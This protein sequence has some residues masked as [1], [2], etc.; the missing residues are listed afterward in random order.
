M[1]ARYLLFDS[2]VLDTLRRTLS[3]RGKPVALTPKAVEVLMLLA[4]RAG[5][6]ITKELLLETLWPGDFA[7]ETSLAQHVY[8]LRKALAAYGGDELIATVPRR[9]YRFAG[10]ARQAERLEVAAPTHVPESLPVRGERALLGVG[11]LVLAVVLA[12]V[13]GRMFAL[14][15]RPELAQLG[16]AAQR[17]YVL[18]RY[19][20]NKRDEINLVLGQREFEAVMQL[21]PRSALGYSGAADVH[22]QLAASDDAGNVK[23][24]L[25]VA[26]QL[27]AQ[28]VAVDPSSAEA[29]ASYG[30]ALAYRDRAGARREYLR[31]IALKPNY[32]SAHQWYANLSLRDGDFATSISEFRVAAALEPTSVPI[33]RWLGFAY[34]YAGRYD[35]A[36]EQ[37]HQALKLDPQ[38]GGARLH[39]A[40][41]LEQEDRYSE[42]IAQLKQ[43]PRDQFDAS[44]LAAWTAY[45]HALEGHADQA[46][47]E[48][49]PI[50]HSRLRDRVGSPSIAAVLDAAGHRSEA[51]AYLKRSHNLIEDASI[52]PR[53][54]PRI[55]DLLAALYPV[56][57]R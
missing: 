10:E 9:G 15:A 7:Q 48:I 6:V 31:A 43:L 42:A 13:A 50:L 19:Y 24:E 52:F 5:Q 30:F 53:Y 1:E 23:R 21:A 44:Q 55:G 57:P 32:P 49:E 46:L 54:D 56:H 16:P 33:A 51:I 20:W 29:H 25:N 4:G 36:I 37:L 40:L 17:H 39:L 18:G 34:Y 28:A 35:E 38:N 41:A 47:A 8:L 2:F 45:A 22:F 11:A 27:A 14:S 26:N 3:H 12:I